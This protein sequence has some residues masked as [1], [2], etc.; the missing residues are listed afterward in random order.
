MLRRC[1]FEEGTLYTAA[2]VLS[3]EDVA[4]LFADLGQVILAVGLLDMRQ[5]FSAFPRAMYPAPEQIP[6]RPHVRGIDIGLGQHTATQQ[7]RNF[8]G[9]NLRL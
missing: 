4:T 1:E 3:L 5:Q 2:V 7:Y 6:G 9:I 8:L